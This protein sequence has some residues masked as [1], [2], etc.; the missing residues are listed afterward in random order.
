M[1]KATGGGSNG[2]DSKN[3]LYCSFAVKVRAG[4]QIELN[5]IICDECMK[6][7]MDIVREENKST[8]VKDETGFLPQAICDGMND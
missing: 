1:T 2:A 3:T 5:S 7:C 8:F 4:A 6:L